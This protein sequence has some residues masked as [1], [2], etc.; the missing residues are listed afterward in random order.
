MLFILLSLVLVINGKLFLNSDPNI[1]LLIYGI[2]VTTIIFIT[3]YIAHTRYVDPSID[4][5]EYNLNEGKPKPFISIVVAVFNEEKLISQCLDALI[6]SSYRNREIIVVND[7]STDNTAQVLRQY[8]KYSDVR[9]LNLEKNIG[10]KKAIAEGL[11]LA[12]GDIFVFTD[13]DSVVARDAIERIIEIFIFDEDVGAVSGHGRA[14]NAEKNILTKVQDSW[15]EGQYSI[16]KAYESVYGAVTCVSGPLA[17]FRKSAI[18]NFIP[19]WANDRFLA[20]EF[21]FA[22]DRTLTA[23]VLG[24]KELGYSNQKKYADSPF[25]KEYPYPLKD[26]K[27][28]YCKSAKVWTKVPETFVKVLK[29]HIRWKKSFIRSV[30]LTGTFYWRKPF[31]AA[32]RYYLGMMYVFLG[33]FIVFRHLVYFPMNGEFVAGALYLSGIFFVGLLYGLIYKLENP[34]SDLWVYRPLMSLMSTLI[35]SWFIFY[36]LATI[37]KNVWHRG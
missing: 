33:P 37:R 6:R 17:V 26:W 12:K 13:S 7:G 18:Y 3:F 14:L 28:L 25:V 11:S 35:L 34:R 9:I 22:T 5:I 1:F 36:S 8:E 23:F 4:I 20:K 19:A 21:R 16:K 10:K 29:Q 2:S 30:F 31:M 32:A 15:Y 24:G 27:I